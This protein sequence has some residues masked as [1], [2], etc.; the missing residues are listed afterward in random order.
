MQFV[1]QLASLQ[2]YNNSSH[3]LGR[4]WAICYHSQFN[5]DFKYIC[6]AEASDVVRTTS[7]L[8]FNRNEKRRYKINFLRKED[9]A[10]TEKEFRFFDTENFM[11]ETLFLVYV[12]DITYYQCGTS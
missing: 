3:L 12:F 8:N 7:S 11:P 10:D 6:I 5:S 2:K 9:L 4:C 1:T